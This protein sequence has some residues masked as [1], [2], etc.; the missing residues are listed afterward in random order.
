MKKVFVKGG[1]TFVL[2]DRKIVYLLLFLVFA[3]KC[4]S[5]TV[6]DEGS[7]LILHCPRSESQNGDLLVGV[8]VATLLFGIFAHANSCLLEQIRTSLNIFGYGIL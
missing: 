6:V 5:Q 3:Q 2:S 1:S 8:L 7:D 4:L